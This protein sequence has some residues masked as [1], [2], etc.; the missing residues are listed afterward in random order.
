MVDLIQGDI[1]KAFQ[2]GE[3]TNLVHCCNVRGVMGGGVAKQIA[4][5]YPQCLERYQAVC[6]K[7]DNPEKLL[8]TY[9]HYNVGNDQVIYNLFGQENP[10]TNGRQV[11]YGYLFKGLHDINARLRAESY[12]TGAPIE[13]ACPML[14]AGSARGDWNII[15]EIIETLFADNSQV[16]LTIYSLDPI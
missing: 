8:G 6:D 2:K 10:S 5:A 3:V 16:N 14:G 12:R 11:H 1:V 7:M 4:Q 13:L 9:M 15:L